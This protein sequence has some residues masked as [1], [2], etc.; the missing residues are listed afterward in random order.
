MSCLP[1]AQDAYSGAGWTSQGEA[2]ASGVS[3]ECAWSSARLPCLCAASQAAA[4][5]TEFQRL[6]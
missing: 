6:G 1:H 5:Q 2:C 3:S 4:Y